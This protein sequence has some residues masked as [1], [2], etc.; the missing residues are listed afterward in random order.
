[1]SAALSSRYALLVSR[2]C[3]AFDPDFDSDFDFDGLRI[4]LREIQWCRVDVE[5]PKRGT[6]RSETPPVL[7]LV[8]A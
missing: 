2:A 8:P 4:S 3:G 5:R 7:R 1:V 6:D